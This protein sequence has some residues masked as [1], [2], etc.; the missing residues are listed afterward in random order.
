MATRHDTTPLGET[1]TRFGKNAIT[2]DSLDRS[3]V[4]PLYAYTGCPILLLLRNCHW[5]DAAALV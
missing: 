5:R 4:P 3:Q 1:E 2:D